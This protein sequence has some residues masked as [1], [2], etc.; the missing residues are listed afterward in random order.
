MKANRAA[1]ESIDYA[2]S[3]LDARSTRCRSS[4]NLTPANHQNRWSFP[5]PA[6]T[7]LQTN[8]P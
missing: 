2:V 6:D 8:L 7:I 3:K 4:A 1:I 5:A